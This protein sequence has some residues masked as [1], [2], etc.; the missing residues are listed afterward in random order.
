MKLFPMS[1]SLNLIIEWKLS[2][3]NLQIGCHILFFKFYHDTLN[4]HFVRLY[5]I[6]MVQQYFR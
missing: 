5:S 3:S 1:D 4:T 6:V 2:I